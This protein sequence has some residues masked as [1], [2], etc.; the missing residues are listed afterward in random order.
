MNY[1]FVFK[2]KDTYPLFLNNNFNPKNGIHKLL[3]NQILSD[4]PMLLEKK[5][6]L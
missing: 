5:L 2:L 4:S 6:N 1:N 3:V